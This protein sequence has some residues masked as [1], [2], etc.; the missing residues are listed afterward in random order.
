MVQEILEFHS[1]AKIP[2]RSLNAALR[3]CVKGCKTSLL[4]DCIQTVSHLIDANALINSEDQGRTALMIACEAGYIELVRCLLDHQALVNI[5]DPNKRTALHYAI[6]AK[7]QNID[8]VQE[9]IKREVPI[10]DPACDGLTPLLLAA[11]K[12]HYQ[13]VNI[14]L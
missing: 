1:G 11:Q 2:K 14:L 8:V 12:G 5:Q 13:I 4:D 9:L 10:N 3:E 7:A 6:E